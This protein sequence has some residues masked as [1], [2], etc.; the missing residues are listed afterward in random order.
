[1]KIR[2]L[3]NPDGKQGELFFYTKT[4]VTVMVPVVVESEGTYSVTNRVAEVKL[5]APGLSSIGIEGIINDI[6]GVEEAGDG[7]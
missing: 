7:A 3:V 4:G 5:D 2:L 6:R 1:M